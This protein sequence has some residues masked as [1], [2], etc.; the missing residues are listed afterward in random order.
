MKK[1]VDTAPVDENGFTMPSQNSRNSSEM[2][3]SSSTPSVMS[4]ASSSS[5]TSSSS[6]TPSV[7]SSSSSTQSVMSSSSSSTPR[8]PDSMESVDMSLSS[9]LELSSDS[10]PPTLELSY[11]AEMSYTSSPQSVEPSF[12]STPIQQSIPP[13][14][15]PPVAIV[16]E[17]ASSSENIASGGLLRPELIRRIR[18]KS[19]SRKNFAAKLVE[20]TFDKDTRSR[21]NVAGKL[22]KLKLNP[23]LIE[24]VKSLV[25]QHFP[26]E[27]NE[28]QETEWPLCVVAIDE[29]NRRLNKAKINR[30][31]K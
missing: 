20:V 21:S 22:G 3:P 8:P 17:V 16:E 9:S 10:I 12:A 6:T 18:R 24:Y 23:I 11:D 15:V 4:S 14:V 26:L 1:I 27:E 31:N 28:K 2:L 7:T 29:K 25:F 19:C 13:A 30:N 5:V